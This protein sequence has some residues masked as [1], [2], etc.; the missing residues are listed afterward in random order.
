MH[1]REEEAGNGPKGHMRHAVQ[2]NWGMV[3]IALAGVLAPVASGAY[4]ASG[5]VLG[6][7]L[8]GALPQSCETTP[9]GL[10]IR[11]G[12][13]RRLVPYRALTLVSPCPD[14]RGS[15]VLSTRRVRIEW[16]S[17]ARIVPADRRTFLAEIAS[18]APHL[19]QRGPDLV[20]S[21]V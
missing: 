8:L 18:R 2:V 5:V 19:S 14:A 13:T 16:G 3:L 11:T 12:L 10:L 17:H 20:R 4:W 15:L 9:R 1:R 6:V 7:L 21:Y